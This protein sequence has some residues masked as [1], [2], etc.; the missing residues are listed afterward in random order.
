MDR[1]LFLH[2]TQ[3]FLISLEGERQ[4]S[5]HTIRNYKSDLSQLITFWE[6]IEHQEATPIPL[7]KC[8]K[9][10]IIALFY[11]KLSPNSLT[12]KISCLRSL[13]D[14]LKREGITLSLELHRPKKEK[15]LPVALSVDELFYLLDNIPDEQLA[16]Q[17]PQ[18]DRAIFELIYASGIRCS[19]TVAIRLQDIDMHEKSITIMGKGKKGRLVLFGSKAQA[20]LT[21]YLSEEREQLSKKNN[22]LDDHLFLNNQGKALSTRTIQRIFEMFRS[23]LLQGRSLTPHKIRHSFAT[24]LLNQGVDLRMI[25]ELLGHESIATTELYTHVSQQQLAKMCDEKHPLNFFPLPQ[26][27]DDDL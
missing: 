9:R 23:Y 8:I 25:Q 16:T 4:Y 19:E 6:R 24:H 18:R 20:Q 10:F 15:K 22:F 26:Q 12:R 2:Y 3:Q 27:Q 7:H 21:R 13:K 11:K 14:F 5:A 1:E 17:F